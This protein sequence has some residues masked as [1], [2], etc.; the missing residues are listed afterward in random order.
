MQMKVAFIP[1]F[2]FKSIAKGR[3][4]Y[5]EQMK[6]N[7]MSEMPSFITF[8]GQTANVVSTSHAWLLIKKAF[9]CALVNVFR[10]LPM[11]QTLEK[12]IKIN[13]ESFQWENKQKTDI[14]SF[15]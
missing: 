13:A 15:S 6:M 5:A 7:Y 11:N 1:S 8:K 14:N 2:S 9:P 10:S 3:G 4:I 12:R